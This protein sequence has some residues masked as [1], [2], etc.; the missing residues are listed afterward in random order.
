MTISECCL[1][2]LLPYILFEKYI[3]ILVLEMA[4][5]GNR[6][7]AS[8][9]GTLS[10]P[11]L[12]W[13]LTLVFLSAH[14]LTYLATFA[15]VSDLPTSCVYCSSVRFALAYHRT[16]AYHWTPRLATMPYSGTDMTITRDPLTHDQVNKIPRTGYFV[17]ATAFDFEST[18]T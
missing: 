9:I 16:L 15:R 7:R 12:S 4:C 13:L 14:L 8:C 2:K 6:H 10:F 11:I 18:S 17:A 1:I 3:Y 5:P